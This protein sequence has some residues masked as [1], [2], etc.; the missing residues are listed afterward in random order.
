MRRLVLATG[1]RHKVEELAAIV[2][3][4]G[5]PLQV[6]SAR[7]AG[8]APAIAEDQGSFVAHALAK[9][10]GIAAWLRARGEP[11]ETL[12][13]ADDS[14]ICVDALDGAPGVESA[15]FAGPAA[16]DAANNRRLVAELSAR[17]LQRSPAHYLCV[18]ALTRVDAAPLP[19]LPGS[20]AAPTPAA[21]LFT[22]RWDGEVR[23]DPRGT[24]GFGYDPHFW[25]AG[26]ARAS[27]EL[28]PAEKNRV[29]HR[30]LATARLLTALPAALTG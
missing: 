9:A 17:G 18:L 6:L 29:S 12:V 16:D 24:G 1:N 14:G 13:L 10:L 26:S 20:E 21:R 11:G 3:A 7:D 15:N 19:E 4:A 28:D 27:A 8:P 30:G 23:S 25:P 2:R 5:L 22:G